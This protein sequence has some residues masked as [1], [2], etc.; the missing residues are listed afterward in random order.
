MVKY[1]SD[2]NLAEMLA[3]TLPK[4]LTPRAVGQFR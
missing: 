4:L 1:S 2:E 3:G